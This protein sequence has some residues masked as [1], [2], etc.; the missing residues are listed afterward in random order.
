MLWLRG[1]RCVCYV[2]GEEVLYCGGVGT[3][4]L[5]CCTV[6]Y[7]YQAVNVRQVEFCLLERKRRNSGRSLFTP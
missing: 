7:S 4:N 2:G 1:V 5:L 3:L 6:M